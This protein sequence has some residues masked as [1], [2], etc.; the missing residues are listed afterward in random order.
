MFPNQDSG[1]SSVASCLMT[2]GVEGFAVKVA[3]ALLMIILVLRVDLSR[4]LFWFVVRIVGF[5]VGDVGDVLDVRGV[6]GGVTL[7]DFSLRLYEHHQHS[8]LPSFVIVQVYD[9]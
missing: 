3:G 9:A 4:V 5:N 7:R 8:S 6:C 1:P 2:R